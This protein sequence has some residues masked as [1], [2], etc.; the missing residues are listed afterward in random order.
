MT[1]S[2]LHSNK[3]VSPNW[4]VTSLGKMLI[5]LNNN[6]LKYIFIYWLMVISII[7]ILYPNFF[8]YLEPYF[9]Y[10]LSL[11]REDYRIIK[12]IISVVANVLAMILSWY[13]NQ[14]RSLSF[15]VKC[16]SVGWLSLLGIDLVIQPLWTQTLRHFL[17]HSWSNVILAMHSFHSPNPLINNIADHTSEVSK[18]KKKA[19]H[20]NFDVDKSLNKSQRVFVKI[21]SP[22]GLSSESSSTPLELSDFLYTDYISKEFFLTPRELHR[23]FGIFYTKADEMIRSFKTYGDTLKPGSYEYNRMMHYY[24]IS[25]RQWEQDFG[26]TTGILKKYEDNVPG[27]AKMMEYCNKHKISHSDVLKWLRHAENKGLSSNMTPTEKEYITW[28]KFRSNP[29]VFFE[30]VVLPDRTLIQEFKHFNKTFQPEQINKMIYENKLVGGA[31]HWESV[32]GRRISK[33]RNYGDK[34]SCLGDNRITTKIDFV[35]QQQAFIGLTQYSNLNETGSRVFPGKI[36]EITEERMPRTGSGT[37]TTT[38]AIEMRKYGSFISRPKTG[39]VDDT[40]TTMVNVTRKDVWKTIYAPPVTEEH[41]NPSQEYLERARKDFIDHEGKNISERSA[42]E[43]LRDNTRPTRPSRPA[44]RD[45]GRRSW[46]FGF[47]DDIPF[48]ITS[49]DIY[50]FLLGLVCVSIYFKISK[51]VKIYFNQSSS[52]ESEDEI[53][54]LELKINKWTQ[55]IKL[56]FGIIVFSIFAFYI[57]IKLF[58][59]ENNNSWLN[60]IE[61]NLKFIKFLITILVSF[62]DLYLS[63]KVR[64]GDPQPSAFKIGLNFISLISIILCFGSFLKWNWVMVLIGDIHF[65]G[66]TFFVVVIKGILKCYEDHLDACQIFYSDYEEPDFLGKSTDKGNNIYAMDNRGESSRSQDNS[67]NSGDP[68]S[69]GD[70]YSLPLSTWESYNPVQHAVLTS[71]YNKWESVRYLVNLSNRWGVIPRDRKV[72]LEYIDR[73]N[74]EISSYESQFKFSDNPELSIRERAFKWNGTI[75]KYPHK[76]PWVKNLITKEVIPSGALVRNS[77]E[78]TLIERHLHALAQKNWDNVRFAESQIQPQIDA[79]RRTEV[80]TAT[81]NP[82]L[83][84]KRK[85]DE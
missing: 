69:D 80:N 29:K 26:I 71:A 52:S 59:I 33:L 32:K 64:K 12:I 56:I 51:L 83:K 82:P 8:K 84:G 63:I 41:K 27:L 10:N 19:I 55:W 68:S 78:G 53:R 37:V 24:L 47:I 61:H 54:E 58:H 5:H 66:V 22:L 42:P 6:K 81:V 31:H 67:G 70:E 60:M 85:R 46:L 57:Y 35:W 74:E 43:S 34:L 23:D 72:M 1:L 28:C 73:Y 75:E 30:K 11:T 7:I 14:L 48:D 38:P 45:M 3:N 50:P 21:P 49:F 4:N 16:L 18:P 62:L 17:S 9:S 13:T 2:T 15:V 40:K 79:N 20:L 76:G 39:V 44:L 77:R 65:W 25:R 36:G